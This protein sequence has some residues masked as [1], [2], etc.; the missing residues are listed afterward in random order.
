MRP[1]TVLALVV[2]RA[3]LQ[4][5]RIGAA[6]PDALLHPHQPV[7]PEIQRRRHPDASA[8]HRVVGHR[9][10][11]GGAPVPELAH[12]P[13][14]QHRV[15]AGGVDVENAID[16]GVEVR[17]QLGACVAGV[18]VERALHAHTVTPGDEV[19]V[20]LRASG[21]DALGL[22][23]AQRIAPGELLDGLAPKLQGEGVVD[24]KEVEIR[25]RIHDRRRHEN[26]ERVR[27]WPRRRGV[28]RRGHRLLRHRGRGRRVVN[29]VRASQVATESGMTIGFGAGFGAGADFANKSRVAH[30]VMHQSMT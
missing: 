14:E 19:D 2:R 7:H 13:G 1:G 25:D 18:L 20:R 3:H 16:G 17:G 15:L 22:A 12:V 30:V 24:P 10:D 5:H 28:R 27:R 8:R 26:G 9:R 11:D 21:L 4:Q 6:G 23:A 29:H